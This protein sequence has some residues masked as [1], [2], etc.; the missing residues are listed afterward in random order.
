MEVEGG[1]RFHS[2][3]TGGIRGKLGHRFGI[4]A[5]LAECLDKSLWRV[6]GVADAHAREIRLTFE[7][8]RRGQ[9][10]RVLGVGTVDR[11]EDDR[12]VLAAATH[13]ARLIHAPCENHSAVPAYPPECRP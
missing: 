3:A 11:I 1:R 10:G 6:L 2:E 4:C 9:C 7:A 13:G 5:E 12:T 8:E